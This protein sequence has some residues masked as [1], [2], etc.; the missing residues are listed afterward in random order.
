LRSLYGRYPLIALIGL[1]SVT[2]L[3]FLGGLAHQAEPLTIRDNL[4]RSIQ[5]LKPPTRV[6]SLAPSITEML[7]VPG[8]VVPHAVRLLLGAD[9]RLLFPV[10]VLV[11]GRMFLLLAYTAA[12]TLL[13]STE[14]PVGII[15]ALAGGPCFVYLLM[16]RKETL[17]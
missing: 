11:G 9:H 4:S 13:A 14:I 6:I 12:R 8:L 17:S 1:L 15:T 16:R 5:F 2:I 3:P 10:S 7:F